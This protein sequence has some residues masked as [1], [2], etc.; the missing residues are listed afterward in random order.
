MIWVSGVWIDRVHGLKLPSMI[1]LFTDS[2]EIAGSPAIQSGAL[3]VLKTHK[4][5]SNSISN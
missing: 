5:K 3:S 4:F 1:A 2:S